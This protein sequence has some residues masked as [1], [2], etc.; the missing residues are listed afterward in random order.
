[1]SENYR[2][3]IVESV[4][5]HVDIGPT[6]TTKRDLYAYL[7][8]SAGRLGSIKNIDVPFPGG[9]LHKSFHPA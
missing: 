5:E 6:N 7:V 3:E 9:V 2:R 8:F 4:V 1:M